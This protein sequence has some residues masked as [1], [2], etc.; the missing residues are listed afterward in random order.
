MELKLWPYEAL[1]KPAEEVVDFGDDLAELLKGLRS[2]LR[3]LG[4]IGISA[5]QVGVS[6]RV[7]IIQ[8][9]KDGEELIVVN[10][11][12]EP[13]PNKEGV[14]VKVFLSNEGCLSLPGVS[15]RLKYIRYL[16]V[17]LTA[18]DPSGMPFVLLLSGRDAVAVQHELDHLEGITILDRMSPL[19]RRLARKRLLKKSRH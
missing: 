8:R 7:A 4:G 11:T 18:Q 16:S 10:P 17:R 15:A 3:Q 14:A 19:T 13:E 12:W 9:E 6:K 1:T 5:P 2:S